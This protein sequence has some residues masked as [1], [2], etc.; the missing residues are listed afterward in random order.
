MSLDEARKV[1]ANEDYL[2]WALVAE[3][4]RALGV[5]V[6]SAAEIWAAALGKPAEAKRKP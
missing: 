6:E 5:P 3:A 2:P 1:L 4:K